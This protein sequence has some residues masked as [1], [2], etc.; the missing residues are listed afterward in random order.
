MKEIDGVTC[1]PVE[2]LVIDVPEEFVGPVMEKLGS[3]KAELLN[4]LPPEK[5]Y[6]VLS[7]GSPQEAS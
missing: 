3:R 4:M 6:T 1:E 7:S 2:D 5:G